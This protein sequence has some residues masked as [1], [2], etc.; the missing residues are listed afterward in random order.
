MNHTRGIPMD[1]AVGQTFSSGTPGHV[2]TEFG[3]KALPARPR[4]IPSARSMLDERPPGELLRRLVA[5]RLAIAQPPPY[6]PLV[7]GEL[8][9]AS[10]A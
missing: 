9:A 4:S 5:S 10:A 2:E 3:I 6:A 1:I 7:E 8:S